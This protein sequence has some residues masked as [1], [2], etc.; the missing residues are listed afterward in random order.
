MDDT[1]NL[2]REYRDALRATPQP[3]TLPDDADWAEILSDIPGTS[4]GP[5]RDADDDETE[6]EIPQQFRIQYTSDE[7]REIIRELFGRNLSDELLG[8]MANVPRGEA[9]AGMTVEVSAA[10]NQFGTPSLSLDVQGQGLE[11]QRD[12]YRDKSGKLIVANRSFGI[13]DQLPSG[14]TNPLKGLGLDLFAG[15]VEGLQQAG[16]EEI[17]TFAAGSK[18]SEEYNGYYTWARMGYGGQIPEGYFDRLPK[19]F[20]DAMGDS[21]EIRDL[22]DMPGGKEAWQEYGG[23]MNMT[24]DLSEGSRNVK[25]LKAYQEERKSQGPRQ[26]RPSKKEKIAAREQAEAA[27]DMAAQFLLSGEEAADESTPAVRAEPIYDYDP[28]LHGPIVSA[29]PVDD[30][31][32]ALNVQPIW[33]DVP[34]V[35]D[36]LN[37]QPI[38]GEEPEVPDALNV[39]P[40]SSAPATDPYDDVIWEDEPASA[41]PAAN[42]RGRTPES[43]PWTPAT[44]P[45]AGMFAEG[46]T[47]PEGQWGIAGESGP[48][49]VSGPAEI[50]PAEDLLG[51]V[52]DLAGLPG[53]EAEASEGTGWE[54]GGSSRIEELLQQMIGV[55]RGSGQGAPTKPEPSGGRPLQRQVA[56]LAPRDLEGEEGFPAASPSVNVSTTRGT[57]GAGGHGLGSRVPTPAALMSG[58]KGRPGPSRQRSSFLEPGR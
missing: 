34:E 14:E 43:D 3:E 35:P 31:P 32:D 28:Q 7:D 58:G 47:I 19:N 18:N 42:P 13:A 57:G 53:E 21:R 50:T 51:A 55:L 15:Q 48:E 33:E 25:A 22:F 5:T 41:S 36:A 8:M 1:A 11:A 24:F 6:P 44:K 20:Q 37:V 23:S 56:P 2:L 10:R 40:A 45:F 30:I 52:D 9:G 12:F 29:E 49:V 38:W 17:R 46:G 27:E 26:P 39:Q 16:V 4:Q 54:S